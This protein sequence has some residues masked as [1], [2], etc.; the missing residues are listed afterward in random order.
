LGQVLRATLGPAE[1]GDGVAAGGE[2]PLTKGV[3]AAA[4]VGGVVLAIFPQI[5]LNLI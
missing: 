2:S 5:I 4:L 3:A 1:E